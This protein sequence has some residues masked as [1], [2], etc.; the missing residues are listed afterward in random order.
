M[1]KYLIHE[2]QEDRHERLKEESS[3][4]LEIKHAILYFYNIYL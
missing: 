1:F 2:H 4:T 3:E